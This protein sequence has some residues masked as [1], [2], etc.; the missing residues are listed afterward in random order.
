[1]HALVQFCTR[2]WLSSF[3]DAAQW[4]QRFVALM[5]QELPSG[6]YENWVRCQQL[7][8]HVEPLFESEPAGEEA[9]KAWA[10]VLSN[11]A[12]YLWMQGSYSTAQQ[13][14]ARALAAREGVLGVDAYQTLTSVIVLALALRAQ[15]KYEE[16]ETLNRRALEGYKKKLGERHPD[17]LTSMYCLAYLLHTLHRYTEAAEL[18]QRVCDGRTQ[19]LGLDHPHTVAC[20]NHFI[21]MQQEAEAARFT[22]RRRSSKYTESTNSAEIGKNDVQ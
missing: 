18:Y 2:V 9:W 7:L 6:E 5:A 12:W 3:G 13:V 21:A 22:E 17:T 19:Q 14:A 4:E 10:Q 8:P 11:A 16:A 1:M 15:G 20:R